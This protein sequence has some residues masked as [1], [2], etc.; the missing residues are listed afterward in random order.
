MGRLVSDKFYFGRSPIERG[1]LKSS[2]PYTTFPP[3]MAK[4]LASLKVLPNEVTVDQLL[5]F[6]DIPRAEAEEALAKPHESHALLSELPVAIG[7]DD[8]HFRIAQEFLK[9]GARQGAFH[10]STSAVSIW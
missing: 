7:L 8:S 4:R 6:V 10:C 5:S 3:Q 9:D 2:D 1:V